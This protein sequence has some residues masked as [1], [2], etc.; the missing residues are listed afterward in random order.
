M[1]LSLTGICLV[2]GA[3]LAGVNQFTAGPI[4]VAK[5]TALEEAIKAVAPEFDNKPTEDVYMAVS[6][7]GDSLKIY[8]AKKGGQVVGGAVESNTKK[9]FSGEIRVIVGFDMDGKIL[10]YS[11]L[12][13]AETPGLGAKNKQSVLGRTIPDG[14]LKVTKDGG[15]VD[16]ITAA[17]ISSRAFLDAVNRAYSAFAGVDGLTGATS[18]DNK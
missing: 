3:I 10:N 14:G 5:A 18:T 2:A 1:L 12:Q 16:A 4:A 11:V 17:T 9:G 6:S 15:D 8:P 7:D 13:H